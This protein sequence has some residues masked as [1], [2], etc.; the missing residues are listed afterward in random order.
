MT[1]TR[2]AALALVLTAMWPAA[3]SAAPPTHPTVVRDV[4]TGRYTLGTEPLGPADNPIQDWIQPDTQIEPSIAVNPEHPKNVVTVYQE[5]RIASGGD[6]TNGFATSFDGGRSWIAGELPK[7]T[8]RVGQGGTWERASDAVVAFGPG[9]MAYANSLVFDQNEENGLPSGIAV[10]V[11]KDGGRTWSAPVV[12]QDD[13][14]GGLNDKNWVVVDQSDAPGHHKGRVYVI[15]DRVAPV[16]YDYCDH[17]CDQLANWLPNLQTIPG[18]VFPG[19][20][21]GAYPMVMKD[22]GIGIVMEAISGGLPTTF[23]GEGEPD[24]GVGEQVF[25]RAPLAGST[26]WPAPI[27]FLPPVD[28]A[29]NKSNGVR[30][31]RASDGLPAAAVDPDSGT[32]YAVWDDGR[33][34]SDGVND[35]VVSKSTD[36]GVTWSPAA[37]INPGPTGDS[38]NH[39]NVTLAVAEHGVLQVA[40]R[41]RREAVS[42]LAKD[43]SPAIDT[44]VQ[45]SRDGGKTW[46]AP[47]QIN[48]SPSNALYD[49]FSRNG[50]F[51]GDYNQTASA[52]GY[53]YVVREQGQPLYP[54]EPP[55]LSP[56]GGKV[57]LTE[58]GKGHQHQRTWVTLVRD[59]AR[60]PKQ[61]R[62]PRARRTGDQPPA[63]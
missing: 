22:G 63:R 27:G 1:G 26:P 43:F 32:V 45:E 49:A 15:W 6:A 54:G 61:P 51:E 29:T 23:G 2:R 46:S 3:A 20:G 19:Q 9:N 44:F 41:Q 25:I 58:A 30:A 57:V 53:T 31:Q 21:L 33:F 7:L 60:A 34:R 62:S 36:G 50:S 39:Y 13:K 42:G 4:M 8:H 56:N 18:L 40:Y 17:D 35:A 52:G 48:S 11:S 47:L 55:A 10:N 12:F 38:V 28:I 37:R 5:G 59:L 24:L 14:L 16:V